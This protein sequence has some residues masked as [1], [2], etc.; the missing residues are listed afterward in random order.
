MGWLCSL[1]N[2]ESGGIRCNRGRSPVSEPLPLPRSVQRPNAAQ[3]P[4]IRVG[5][6]A[7]G[8]TIPRPAEA[9]ALAISDQRGT[10]GPDIVAPASC[11]IGLATTAPWTHQPF[12]STGR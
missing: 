3:T 2:I 5:L 6:D 8:A 12:L 9:G 4:R 7:A 1:A 11:P 10:P